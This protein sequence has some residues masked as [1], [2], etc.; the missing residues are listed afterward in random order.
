LAVLGGLRGPAAALAADGWSSYGQL[1]PEQQRQLQ[2]IYSDYAG[3]LYTLKA[4]IAAKRADLEARLAAPSV[5]SE[6]ID[7]LVEELNAL[8]G[9][10][11]AERVDMIV[12]MRRKGLPYFGMR[13]GP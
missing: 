8:K 2:E 13:P 1:S 4:E 10:L 11:F 3:R 7:R 6:A 12:E 5:E 9:E